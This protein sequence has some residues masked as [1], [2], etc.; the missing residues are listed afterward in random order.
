M[1]WY[2]DAFPS[3]K[4]DF[5]K[6]IIEGYPD[7]IKVIDKS[8]RG[9]HLWILYEDGNNNNERYIVLYLL[10][11]QKKCWGYKPISEEMGP[12]YWDCPKRFLKLQPNIRNEYSKIWREEVLNKK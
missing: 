12:S 11:S 8:I 7:Y 5:I 1:G 9:N 3:T 6:N 2:F 4:E 10:S